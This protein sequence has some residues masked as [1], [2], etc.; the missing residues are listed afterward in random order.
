MAGLS[1]GL[2][3]KLTITECTLEEDGS[4]TAGTNSF[5][6]MLNP[7][8]YSR[9][10][11][12]CY[13]QKQTLGQLGNESKFNGIDPENITINLILDGTGVVNVI[14]MTD[15]NT[16]LQKLNAVIYNYDGSEHETNHVKLVWGSFLFYGRLKNMSVEYTLFKPSGEPLRAKVKLDFTSF[17]SSKQQ[18][19]T[20]NNSSPD[21]SHL[22][23]VK[24][25]DTLPLLCYRIY[26]NS[27]YYADVA[28]VNN[29]DD[30]R[31]L[32]PGT[33]LHFPPLR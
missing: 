22:V 15:V 10:Y 12:I 25:G 14:G 1:T 31:N 29:L 17:A 23:E 3:E 33:K 27:A 19:L 28:K 8:S 4:I 11:S 2:K 16:Q 21:L 32:K 30:F 18:A 5:E 6:V 24:A 26:K 13:N 20:A 9:N 7:P